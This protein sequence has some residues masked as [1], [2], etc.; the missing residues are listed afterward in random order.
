MKIRVN[1][2]RR[3]N[4]AQTR[5]AYAN[6]LEIEVEMTQGQMMDALGEFLTKVTYGEWELWKEHYDSEIKA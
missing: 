1:E 6:P 4:A 5:G 3:I 2:I